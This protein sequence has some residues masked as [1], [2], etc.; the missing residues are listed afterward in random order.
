MSAALMTRPTNRRYAARS[1][2]GSETDQM[3]VCRQTVQPATPAVVLLLT[4]AARMH[5]RGTG[6]DTEYL[7]LGMC[8]K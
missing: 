4:Q 1:S 5:H 7:S 8:A 3:C 6:T 2:G